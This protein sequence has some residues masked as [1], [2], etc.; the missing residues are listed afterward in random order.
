MSAAADMA[1]LEAKASGSSFYKA[2]KILPSAQR[3]AMYAVY[4]FCREVDDIADEGGA[5]AEKRAG[6]GRWRRDIDALFEGKPAGQAE[7]LRAPVSRYGLRREGCH[8]VIDGM[9][10]DVGAGVVAPD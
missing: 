2:M 10:M 5:D 3:D 7:F 1:S 6:L 9:E 4:R 8:A